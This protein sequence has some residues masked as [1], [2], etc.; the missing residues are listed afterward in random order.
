MS[1]KNNIK[2]L[3]ITKE[4]VRV[5]TDEQLKG[6]AGGGG[7]ATTAINCT[8]PPTHYCLPTRQHCTTA[9]YCH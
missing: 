7:P 1:N 6:V 4:T 2:K 5:L 9:Y 8:V 3:V